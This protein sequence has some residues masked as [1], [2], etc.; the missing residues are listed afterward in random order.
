MA[1]CLQILVMPGD[2]IVAGDLFVEAKRTPTL[3]ASPPV[4]TATVGIQKLTVE[5]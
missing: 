5:P 1:F 4:H 2:I 3:E